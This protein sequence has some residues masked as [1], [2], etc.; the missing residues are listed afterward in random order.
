MNTEQDEIARLQSRLKHSELIAGVALHLGA[1]LYSKLA[2]LLD[3]W[4]QA[5]VITAAEMLAELEELMESFTEEANG[6]AG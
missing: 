6:R 3:G 1:T 5:G 4:R 2:E